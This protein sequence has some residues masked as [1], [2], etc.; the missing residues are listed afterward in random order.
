[1]E[2]IVAAPSIH[3]WVHRNH[4]LQRGMRMNHRHQRKK[5]VIRNPQHAHLPIRLGNILHQPVNRVVSIGRLVHW[6]RIQRPMNRPVH[7]IVALAPILPAN[8]L[9]HANISA[10]HNRLRRVVIP[11]KRRS[12]MLALRIARQQRRVVRV[13]MSKIPACFAP[14]GISIT[15]CSRTPSRIGIIASRRA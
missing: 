7:H 3:H 12:Q 1:M 9:H 13:R 6:S 4:A 15:V 2:P 11:P 8:I 5:S 14:F 10:L